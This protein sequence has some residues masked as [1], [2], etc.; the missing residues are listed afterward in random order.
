MRQVLGQG[1]SYESLI[2]AQVRSPSPCSHHHCTLGLA[3]ALRVRARE[4]VPLDDQLPLQSDRNHLVVRLRVTSQ[5][6]VLRTNL[7]TNKARDALL[8][9]QL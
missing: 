2:R 6:L 9:N 4:R 1:V 8:E 5:A 7:W 3:I